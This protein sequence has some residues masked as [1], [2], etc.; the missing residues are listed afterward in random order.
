MFAPSLGP[1]TAPREASLMF[2][3]MSECTSDLGFAF[4]REKGRLS[5]PDDMTLFTTGLWEEYC[6]A[7]SDPLAAGG[8]RCTMHPSLISWNLFPMWG[9]TTHIY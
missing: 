1:A 9:R 2:P 7:L 5:L 8:D 6:H 3:A 4:S